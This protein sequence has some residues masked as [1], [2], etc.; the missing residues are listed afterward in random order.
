MW[1]ALASA[2]AVVLQPPHTT[3]HVPSMALRPAQG[4]PPPQLTVLQ[5]RVDAFGL[6]CWQAR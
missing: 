6:R 2:P 4:S 1:T 3:S 5:R